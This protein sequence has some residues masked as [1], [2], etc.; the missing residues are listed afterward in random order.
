[1]RDLDGVRG[2]AHDLI[3]RQADGAADALRKFSR[4]PHSAKRLHGARKALARLRAALHDL[5][6]AAAMRSK[7]YE[8]VQELHSRAGKIRDADILLERLSVYAQRAAG[9][10]REELRRVAR[11]LQKR[12]K[13]ARRRLQTLMDAMPGLRA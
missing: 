11:A 6:D 9:A 4:K 10:E 2:W 13:K 7:L 12:R 5:G 1:M 3:E 8:R